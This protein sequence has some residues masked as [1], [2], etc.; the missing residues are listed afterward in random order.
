[1]YVYICAYTYIHT[2]SWALRREKSMSTRA[3]PSSERARESATYI[4]PHSK[5]FPSET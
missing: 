4:W 2:L 3:I 1:M 5:T